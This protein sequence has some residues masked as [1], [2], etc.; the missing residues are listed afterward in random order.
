[1]QPARSKNIT[2]LR[3]PEN[4]FLVK[5]RENRGESKREQ[6]KNQNL[7]NAQKV[8]ATDSTFMLKVSRQWHEL[9]AG[10]KKK[11]SKTDR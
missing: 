10:L 3:V 8:G 7:S 5:K 2:K 9:L 6:R 1:M 4:N 11:I